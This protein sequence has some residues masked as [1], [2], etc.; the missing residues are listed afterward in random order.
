[1]AI[2]SQKGFTLIEIIVATSIF[3]VVVSAMLTLLN[4]TLKINRRVEGLRQVTQGARNF[5]EALVRDIRNGQVDYSITD[6]ASPCYVGNYSFQNNKSL[7][8]INSLGERSCY[9]L[10]GTNLMLTK[11]TTNGTVTE[12]VNATNIIIDNATF[13]FHVRPTTD[14]K[15]SSP[16]YPGVQPLVTIVANIRAQLSPGEP[17]ANIPYQTT[18]SIDAYDIPHAN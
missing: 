7:G 4:Y 11:K 5:T 12:Q 16:P 8:L 18:I 6:A 13:H 3:V 15:P 1:M 14:P 9:Y 17:S 2:R 10:S